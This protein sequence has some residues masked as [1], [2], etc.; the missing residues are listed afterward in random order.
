MSNV[1]K[2]TSVGGMVCYRV[3]PSGANGE[4]AYSNI[5]RVGR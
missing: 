5:V 2:S 1:D 3:R 4:S